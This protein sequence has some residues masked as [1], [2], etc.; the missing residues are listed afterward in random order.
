MSPEQ[1]QFSSIVGPPAPKTAVETYLCLE[2]GNLKANVEVPAL[3]LRTVQ[4]VSNGDGYSTR[5][6]SRLPRGISLPKLNLVQNVKDTM[7][8][9]LSS[10]TP[11]VQG[12]MASALR[13]QIT[14]SRTEGSNS[15][16]GT[17]ASRPFSARPKIHEMSRSQSLPQLDRAQ[18]ESKSR[19]SIDCFT[20][21]ESGYK[22]HSC[23]RIAQEV[24]DIATHEGHTSVLQQL[25]I[26]LYHCKLSDADASAVMSCCPEVDWLAECAL[27]CPLPMG[28]SRCQV[29]GK[30]AFVNERTKEICDEPPNL[31]VF[32]RFAWCTIQARMRP[33]N[34]SKL[35]S[36]IHKVAKNNAQ[37][38]QCLER[39]WTGPHYDSASGLPYYN[40][41]S[42]DISSWQS[43][44]HELQYV[45]HVAYS[46]LES[47][48]FDTS[49][50]F[51][52]DTKIATNQHFDNLIQEGELEAQR[53]IAPSVHSRRTSSHSACRRSQ[54][55]RPFRQPTPSDDLNSLRTD[56][57]LRI[58]A[59]SRS[60]SAS[61][62]GSRVH[63]QEASRGS[64]TVTPDIQAVATQDLSHSCRSKGS[65]SKG[66]Y[67]I[68]SV[69]SCRAESW[70]LVEDERGPPETFDPDHENEVICSATDTHEQS[71]GEAVIS[72]TSGS[73]QKEFSSVKASLVF[74][75]RARSWTRTNAAA[76]D[77]KYFLET[78]QVANAKRRV[79]H[80]NLSG[81][82]LP[83][84]VK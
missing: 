60:T 28:W 80:R 42:A 48:V 39:C 81:V 26:R 47:S 75:P 64:G 10:R 3:S 33:S 34:V 82:L 2:K 12:R 84:F 45:S 58:A 69:A 11:R 38:A 51:G 50:S 29:N 19:R 27:A 14:E 17:S 8:S 5:S 71:K 23:S 76:D 59:T 1:I 43:P 52:T 24:P 54:Q 79:L 7:T 56:H 32:V 68:K 30:F 40:C 70:T 9:F 77:S 6:T 67:E 4:K 53:W 18:E 46:L 74:A 15:N 72:I 66:R 13:L 65:S 35:A 78:F 20:R 16:E 22:E 63:S 49:G 57:Q 83:P 62:G 44:V 41:P 21:R 31:D 25:L 73:D 37:Q 55:C 36:Y 61:T